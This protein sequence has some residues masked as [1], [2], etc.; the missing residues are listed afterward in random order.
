MTKMA[1]KH[2]LR[3]GHLNVYHLYNKLTD[4]NAF[5]Q[6]EHVDILGIS[7]SRLNNNISDDSIGIP[8]YN[9]FR[10][11]AVEPR[12]TGL[13]V[14]VNHNLQDSI[15]RRL[16]LETSYVE[17]IWLEL[18]HCEKNTLLLGIL[19]RNPASTLCWYDDFVNMMDNV[20][21]TGKNVLLLGDFNIDLFKHNNAWSSTT[22]LFGLVQLVPSA[23]RVTT[24]TSTLIDHI[25]TTD[26]HLV[27]RT[28]VPEI[29]ISDHFPI[30]CSLQS[31]IKRK[32]R[33]H[34]YLS[35]RSFKNFDPKTFL[36]DLQQ[37]PFH[38][39][40]NY[41]D[42]NNALQHWY[43]LFLQV[44]NKHAPARKK[45]VRHPMLPP[46]LTKEVIEA[47]SFRDKLRKNKDLTAYKK[48][49]NKVKSLVRKVKKEYFQKLITDNNNVTTVWNAINT[50]IRPDKTLGH[51]S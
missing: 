12:D 2:D 10:R 37:L 48:Q 30:L 41:T 36:C 39:V 21:A 24:L 27:L 28:W 32:K 33:E 1:P 40:L 8:G 50:F 45:R 15:H 51:S 43:S 22:A 19:Y 26:V 23:T 42:P 4:I 11:D 38:E 49:R 35:Y 13:A 6:S 29:G 47:M 34:T 14:Y 9:V 25:Y 5:I 3:I 16:D 18:K 44:L 17:C 7:E 20:N 31:K 46:W